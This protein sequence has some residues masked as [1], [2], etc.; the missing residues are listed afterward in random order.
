MT[1]GTRRP[2]NERG[3]IKMATQ[4]PTYTITVNAFEAGFLMSMIEGVD[5]QR[6]PA[7]RGLRGQLTALKRDMEKA[8]G[9]V[10]RLLP[11]GMLE[12]K[13]ADGNRIVRPP[14]SW[15]IEGN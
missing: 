4:L 9:V 12:L 6:K 2:H 3:E 10:K 11:N 1:W 15:E 5:E 7:L 8:D 13:D 14:Y